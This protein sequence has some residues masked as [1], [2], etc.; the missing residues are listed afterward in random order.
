MI[1]DKDIQSLLDKIQ[2]LATEHDKITKEFNFLE[3]RIEKL[4]SKEESEEY[5]DQDTLIQRLKA[6]FRDV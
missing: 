2:R 1:T 4:E 5:V 6:H 3:K